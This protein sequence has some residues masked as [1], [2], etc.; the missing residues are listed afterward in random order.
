MALAGLGASLAQASPVAGQPAPEADADPRAALPFPAVPV[1]NA[2]PVPAP[3]TASFSDDWHACRDG[4]SRF[5]RGNDIFAEEG[6]PIVAVEAGVAARVD[7][8]DDSNG[9]LSIWLRGDSGVAYWYA[10]NSANFVTEGQRVAQ[11]QVIGRV[12]RTG[13]ARTTPPHIHFQVNLC[14]ELSSSEPC[15]V[16]P[17]G[18]ITRWVPGQVG[19]GADAVGLYRR[20]K[21]SAEL[22]IERGSAL[23]AFTFGDAPEADGLT[24]AGD[25]NGDGRDT[26]ALYRRNDATFH[27]QRG[28]DRP[29]R[30][31]EFGWP[32]DTDVLPVAGDWN[33]DGRDTVGLY[34]GSDATFHLLRGGDR[35]PRVVEFGWPGAADV[36]PVA[37]DWDGDGRDTL[38]LYRARDGIFRL[39]DEEGRDLAPVAF[40]NPD[41]RD[42]LPIV[43]DWDGDGR[44]TVGLFVRDRSRFRLSGP[45][46]TAPGRG[47]TTIPTGE[48][49][50]P[51]LVPV[52][53]DW[54]GVDLV[55]MDDLDA[56]FGPLDGDE[57]EAIEKQL[58]LLNEAM[59][60]AGTTTPARK[61]AFLATIRSESAFR[62]DAVEAGNPSTYRGRGF[63]QLTGDF[64]YRRAGADLGLDLEA[65]PALAARPAASAAI[66]AWYWSVARDINLAADHLDMAAVNIAVGYAPSVRRDTQ[67]CGDFVRALKW[68]NGGELPDGVNCERSLASYL[69]ALGTSLASSSSSSPSSA[70]SAPAGDGPGTTATD[71]LPGPAA[72]P[73]TVGREPSSTAGS[74][75]PSTSPPSQPSTTGTTRPS[76]TDPPSTD[77]PTTDPPSTDPPTT[78]PTTTTTR[79]SSTSTTQPSTTTTTKPSTTT[80][81]TTTTVPCSSTSTSTTTTTTST[82]TTTQPCPTSP[83][84]S[85]TSTTAPPP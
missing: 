80:S 84:S 33:G 3:H 28:D 12:G 24:V 16:N 38:G 77:P 11:G 55:T 49:P 26:L 57:A 20:S 76:S 66:A 51:D 61:A 68:F 19:G 69:L 64:N 70:S 72:S 1:A 29:P 2:F 34:R 67:R 4:C 62:A 71:P 46:L 7:N 58:P 74:G 17:Y 50:A 78:G 6:T 18:F 40:G 56:I 44:D 79:P 60:R 9:G 22:R 25:W 13:N 30:V 81:T 15:T 35:E 65:K 14:G 63:I 75:R 73:S 82:T 31:L 47:V 54:N 41:A 83:S 45:D 48:A 39:R 59:L 53:G 23:P 36:L 85:T 21:A 52:A 43:G 42:E 5:H 37:G 8:T 32:G 10:H 27:L